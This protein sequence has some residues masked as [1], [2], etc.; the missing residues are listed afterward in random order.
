MNDAPHNTAA[1]IARVIEF[2]RKGN[3]HLTPSTRDAALR[4]GV[5]VSGVTFKAPGQ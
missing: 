1:G 4:L 2:A 5:D 3:W